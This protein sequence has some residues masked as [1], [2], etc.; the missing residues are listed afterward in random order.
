MSTATAT[1]IGDSPKPGRSLI[2]GFCA[3]KCSPA[4]LRRTSCKVQVV[5][6]LKA[7]GVPI[8]HASEFIERG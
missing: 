8:T 2:G 1:Y 3:V 6:K 4:G 7:C 5:R